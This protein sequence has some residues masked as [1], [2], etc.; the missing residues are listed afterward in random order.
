MS[1]STK[2]ALQKKITIINKPMNNAMNKFNDCR[3]KKC[4]PSKTLK[5]EYKKYYNLLTKKC[6]NKITNNT[7]K[8]RIQ[9][10]EDSEY[11]KLFEQHEACSKKKCSKESKYL[12]KTVNEKMKKTVKL[13]KENEK[14]ENE[15]KENNNKSI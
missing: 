4:I 8:C 2:K 13:F 5:K 3:N 7:R 11:K 12:I 1:I 9:I 6:G 14:K 15:K 10:Y